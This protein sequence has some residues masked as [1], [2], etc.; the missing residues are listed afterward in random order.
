MWDV[1]TTGVIFI[2]INGLKFFDAVWVME[3]GRPSG[4]THT[5]A[6]LMYSKVFEEYNIGLGTAIAVCLFIL[7]LLA[8]L[9]SR[10]LLSRESL[11][12]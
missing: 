3:N 11:E 10:R 8:T 5:M 6:T 12:Y 4:K 1:L 9:I 7:V 2:I